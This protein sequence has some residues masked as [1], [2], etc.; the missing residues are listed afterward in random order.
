MGSVF[1]HTTAED[2]KALIEF[3]I[4]IFAAD[5]RDDFVNPSLLRWKYWSEREDF[6]E[7]RSYVIE[8]DGRIVAHAGLWPLTL[9]TWPKIDR[10]VHMIDWAADPATPGAGVSL[11]Q[12][13][14]KSLDFVYAIGGSEMTQSVLPKFG[15][16]TVAE[17]LTWARP[18][19]PW[20]Q[21]LHHQTRDLR[22]ALRLAR[23]I[24]W[25]RIPGK[26][27]ERDWTAVETP[28]AEGIFPSYS[29]RDEAFF[30]YLQKCPVG[31]YLAF[32][33]VQ[34]GQK[35]GFIALLAVR[36]QTRVA[37]IWLENHSV[38]NW[39]VAF[40]LVQDVALKYTGT[41][42]V[43]ARC[44]TQISASAARQAG[45]RLR[46][47][48]PVFLFRKSNPSES[49]PIHFQLSDDDAIFLAGRRTGFLT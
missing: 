47:R 32:H 21:V 49:L 9:R 34:G 5:P 16:R 37:G 44:S 15:F 7:P 25:S 2:E 36:E 35:L 20:K 23:N 4:R 8:K 39:R 13:L 33:I 41:S 6:Q 14:T 26:A 3:L 46:A 18:I 38:E 29:E 42:E 17:T 22:L 48:A 30:R 19:R 40:H 45:M 31:R 1:R 11:L 27:I 12:R 24:W 10:G 28:N 43:V